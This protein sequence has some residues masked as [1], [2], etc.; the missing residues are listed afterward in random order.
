MDKRTEDIFIKYLEKAKYFSGSPV[1]G[2]GGGFKS[3]QNTPKPAATTP[4][5]GTT[6]KPANTQQPPAQGSLGDAPKAPV[7][8]KV[9]FGAKQGAAKAGGF[10]KK[11]ES[12]IL[13]ALGNA[14]QSVGKTTRDFVRAKA[15]APTLRGDSG[16]PGEEM[17]SGPTSDQQETFQQQVGRSRGAGQTARE[18]RQVNRAYAKSMSKKSFNPALASLL[19]VSAGF[20]ASDAVVNASGARGARSITDDQLNL[21]NVMAN[22]RRGKK[23]RKEHS[24][25]PPIQGLVWDEGAKRWRKPENV[26][27]TASEVQ[28]KKRIRGSALGQTAKTP[29]GTSAGKGRGR[30]YSQGRANR[31]AS[32]DIG[33][34]GIEG[35]PSR[36]RRKKRG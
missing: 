34:A 13:G 14:A 8:K 10:G 6:P 11:V 9:A 27:K 15:G 24:P 19:A 26:G 22:R 23:I 28:G 29:G 5:A 36:R 35:K 31:I 20:A 25:L 12:G 3:A 7:A 4:P 21:F 17:E 16:N 32:G 2:A 18:R 1:A 30:G 33:V